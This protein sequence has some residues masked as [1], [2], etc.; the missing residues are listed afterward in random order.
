MKKYYFLISLVLVLL[1][2]GCTETETESPT[3]AKEN[4]ASQSSTEKEAPDK[5][6]PEASDPI[7]EQHLSGTDASTAEENPESEPHISGS[8]SP[9]ES[10]HVSGQ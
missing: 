9:V 2:A 4:P 8:T 3:T 1:L 10:K 6:T 7:K 5:I